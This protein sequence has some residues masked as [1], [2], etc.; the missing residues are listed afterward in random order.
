[1]IAD[2]DDLIDRYLRAIDAEL[3][4]LQR[5]TIDTLFIGGGTPTHFRDEA[6]RRFFGIVSQRFA[7]APGYEWTIEANPEDI[8]DETLDV[9]ATA[10]VNRVSLGVQS[11]HDPKLQTLERGHSGEIATTV[12]RKVADMIE[13]V[14]IDL[15]FAAPNESVSQWRSDLETALSLPITHLS[16]Y[17]LTYEKGTQFWNRKLRGELSPASETAEVA[18]YELARQITA[19]DGLE[20]YEISSFA[21]PEKQCRHNIAYWEGRGWYAAGPGA[22]RFVRGVREGNHRSTTTY[23]KRIESNQSPV[24]E[25]EPIAWEQHAR[26]RAAFGIRMLRGIDLS[27]IGVQTGIDLHQLLDDSITQLQAQGL[28]E[29]TGHHVQLTHDGVM[30]ADMV[31][32]EF[33]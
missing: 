11:F 21:R 2:R 15:I 17:A 32:R 24:A 13:N 25:S 28:V 16:T 26:E 12:V 18:M 1:V 20:H 14:S 3:A 8:D 33:L 30:F 6:L 7:L 5:P 31:A 23:L 29:R 9:I 19:D 22:A 4:L 27:E 10:G